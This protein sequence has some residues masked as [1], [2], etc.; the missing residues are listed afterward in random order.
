MGFLLQISSKVNGEFKEISIYVNGAIFHHTWETF[1]NNSF[2]NDPR[3]C[4]FHIKSRLDKCFNTTCKEGDFLVIFFHKNTRKQKYTDF[5]MSI[6]CFQNGAHI[7]SL[8]N[9]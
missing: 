7:T 8:R 3:K 1:I 6:T 9:N 2:E 5:H 4:Y